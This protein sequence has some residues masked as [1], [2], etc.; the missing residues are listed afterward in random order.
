MKLFEH[1]L[2]FLIISIG[3]VFVINAKLGAGS[4]DAF[5]Y[6]LT[7]LLGKYSNFITLGRI[8]ILNGTL[9][10]FL[11]YMIKKDKKIFISFIFLFLV[12]NF[13]DISQWAFSF[14]SVT[15]YDA[16]IERFILASLGTI[17]I[18][19]G[20]SM[21][22]LTGYQ[23]SPFEALL[24]VLDEKIHNISL[25]K[26]LIDGTYL[27]GAFILGFIYKDVFEQIGI[28]TI[29]LTFLTGILVNHFT[30]K[31]YKFKTRKVVV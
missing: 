6:Y 19:F 13:I 17:I 9:V 3:I 12:G 21:T 15:L 4:L 18:S 1:I 16:L 23:P 28:F 27:I 29:V 5:N 2:G 31:I 24:L 30:K 14:V 26:I 10:M 25:T 20:V 22:I 8:S 7:E 11:A